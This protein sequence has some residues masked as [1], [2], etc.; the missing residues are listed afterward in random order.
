[1][2]ANVQVCWDKFCR[3]WD[4]EPRE[5]PLEP[6]RTCL[7]AAEAAALCD[8]NTIGVVAILGS[9]L[10]GAYE[11]VAGDRGGAR[12]AGQAQTGLDVPIHVDAASGGF[13]APFLDPEL[14][15]DFRLARVQSINASGHKYGLVY[16]NLGWIV[17]RNKDGAARASSC[18]TS[19]TSA[20]L[21]PTFA[22]NF[23]RSGAFVVAQYFTMIRLGREGFRR[24]Q[25]S[26]R[27]HRALAVRRDRGDG[28]SSSSSP[29]APPCP[30]SP[31]AWPT[32]LR[33]TRC[34]TS[35]RDCG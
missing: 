31:S 32:M 3:Y 6:G 28:A 19:T 17:W 34:S 21:M 27:R 11:P 22:L 2:G 10:D 16:P 15:W 7:G 35:R 5:V 30:C 26:S 13:V 23:S 18:S 9:T 33:A 14:V 20:G 1:M 4:V 12:R 29:M 8:E 25:Q 24:V